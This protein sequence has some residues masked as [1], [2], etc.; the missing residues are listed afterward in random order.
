MRITEPDPVPLPVDPETNTET[1]LGV[2]AAAIDL[3]F[4]E[5]A[6]KSTKVLDFGHVPSVD[7]YMACVRISTQAF[8]VAG[9]GVTAVATPPAT[10]A[11]MRNPVPIFK[12][13]ER[14]NEFL[15]VVNEVIIS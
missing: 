1:T 13:V 15:I 8:T 11:P 6:P 14:M 4:M 5:P 2:T 10:K 3:T 9:A 12:E 7:K